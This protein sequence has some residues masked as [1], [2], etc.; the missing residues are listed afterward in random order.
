[1]ASG[2]RFVPITTLASREFN[3]DASGAM[4]TANRGPVFIT[5]RGKPAHVLRSIA[6][7]QLLVGQQSSITELLAMP[8][9]AKVEF[10]PSTIVINSQAAD[11]T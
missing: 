10:N 3:E 4:R 2:A 9:A 11:L 6:D 5:D 8:D 1:V 7:H